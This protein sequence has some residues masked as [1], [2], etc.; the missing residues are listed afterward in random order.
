MRASVASSATALRTSFT[1][2]SLT[3]A[4]M[5]TPAAPGSPTFT[6]ARR[7]EIASCT[8][9]MCAAGTKVRRM[10]VHFCPAFTVISRTTS[11]TKRS[12]SGVPGAASGPSTVAL[13]LSRSATKRTLSR[14]MTGW[15]WSFCAVAAE[16]VKETTSWVLRWS[17]RSPAEP[18][19]S[20]TAPG[21]S[22]PDSIMM[23]KHAS[24]T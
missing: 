12:N 5:V 19:T 23:R 21:G 15:L 1:C 16:P 13:R 9:S 7:P 6:L 3:S 10:A 14:A 2:R 18:V 11:F 17:S 8:A 20:C 22:A 24:V 4:P